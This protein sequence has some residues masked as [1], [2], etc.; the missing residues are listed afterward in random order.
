MGKKRVFIGSSS[1]QKRPLAEAI[2]IALAESGFAR[3][4]GGGPFQAA[5]SRCLALRRLR[6]EI[7]AAVLISPETTRQTKGGTSRTD[8]SSSWHS[9]C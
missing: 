1:E 2:A 5:Q 9:K 7:D 3:C 4:H 8:K 6:T